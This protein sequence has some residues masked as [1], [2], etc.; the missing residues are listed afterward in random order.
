MLSQTFGD[1]WRS[2]CLRRNGQASIDEE[3][4]GFGFASISDAASGVSG[5]EEPLIAELLLF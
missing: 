5:S 1:A 3:L 4:L 2:L